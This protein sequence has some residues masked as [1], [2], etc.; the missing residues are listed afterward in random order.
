MQEALV[1]LW[2]TEE[3]HP[4]K[5]EAWYLQ[6]CRFHLQN[7]RRRG[8]SVDSTKHRWDQM[9]VGIEPAEPA[10]PNEDPWGQLMIS[11]FVA[12]LT[13]WLTPSEKDILL[14]LLEG[15]SARETARRLNVSHT[16]INRHRSQ[17]AAMASKL[18]IPPS[19]SRPELGS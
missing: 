9:E 10:E 15:L 14:C 12:E 3:Q 5:S 8:R 2:H 6:S 18:E 7:C 19:R 1:H 17:I 4:G 13:R 16:L 11:E